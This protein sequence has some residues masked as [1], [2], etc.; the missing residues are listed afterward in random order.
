MKNNRASI[1][2]AAM[3]LDGFVSTRSLALE[4]TSAAA[5]RSPNQSIRLQPGYR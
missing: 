3:S 4:S 2:L 5:V 1:C